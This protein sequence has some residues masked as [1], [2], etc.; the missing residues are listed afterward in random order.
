MRVH[1]V[2]LSVLCKRYEFSGCCLVI[3]VV[4][5]AADEAD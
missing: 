1:H 5:V 3:T 2:A 4:L